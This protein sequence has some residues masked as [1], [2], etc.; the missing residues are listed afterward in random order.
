[1][2]HTT[3][4]MMSPRLDHWFGPTLTYPSTTHC[5]DNMAGV[6]ASNTVVEGSMTRHWFLKYLE[7]FV[8]CCHR[9]ITSS[10]CYLGH[11]HI[12][13][14]LC[15]PFSGYLSILMMDNACIHHGDEIL[16][17]TQCFGNIAWYCKYRCL[18]LFRC[19]H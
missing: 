16:K 10:V 18:K 7:H 15:T 1:M 12:Q 13:M 8:V 4:P 3:S 14:P 2:H 5:P 6:M 19:L 9:C 17:L 11:Y